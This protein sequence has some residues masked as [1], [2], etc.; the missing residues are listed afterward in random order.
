M[1]SERI[2][3]ELLKENVFIQRFINWAVYNLV[4]GKELGRAVEDKI[5]IDQSKQDQGICTG[6][7]LI[8]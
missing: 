6:H 2:T 3:S 7:L 1:N 5:F 8:G 4:N